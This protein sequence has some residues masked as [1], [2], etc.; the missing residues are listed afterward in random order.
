MLYIPHKKQPAI[1]P[2]YNSLCIFLENPS[3]RNFSVSNPAII[4][5]MP[6]AISEIIF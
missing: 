1:I 3:S 6:Y 5:A 2:L 4:H